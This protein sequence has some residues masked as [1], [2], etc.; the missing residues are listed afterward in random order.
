MEKNIVESVESVEKNNLELKEQIQRNTE[1]IER[2]RGEVE[3]RGVR[4]VRREVKNFCPKSFVEQETAEDRSLLFSINT[5]LK[6]LYLILEQ[7]RQLFHL[8][9][10]NYNRKRGEFEKLD[11]KIALKERLTLLAISKDEKK[12]KT[13]LKGVR[14][15]TDE[16]LINLIKK[17][18][19]EK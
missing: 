18:K 12:E 17:F 19:C 8:A 3:V 7:K 6:S 4:G 9:E 11:R 1:K 5:E 14:I 2:L 16:E 13:K 15:Y 10:L